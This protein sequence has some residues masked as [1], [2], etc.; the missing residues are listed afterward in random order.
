M[1][2]VLKS[3]RV[4]FA[5]NPFV[6]I[7]DQAKKTGSLCHIV[8]RVGFNTEEVMVCLVSNT[9]YKDIKQLSSPPTTPSP[10][11]TTSKIDMDQ[12]NSIVKAISAT[13][14]VKCVLY[15]FNP[16]PM[17][18][19][20]LGEERNEKS[21]LLF[22]DCDFIHE[23]VAGIRVRVSLQSFMQSNPLQAEVLY[24]KVVELANFVGSEV[25][26]DMFCGVGTISLFVAPFVRQ[27]IGVEDCK[28]AVEDAEVNKELN[29]IQNVRFICAKAEDILSTSE[30]VNRTVLSGLLDGEYYAPEDV[31]AILNPPRKGCEE[32]LLVAL[33]ERKVRKVVY[34]SCNP[35]SLARDLDVLV[36]KMGYTLDKVSPVDMFPHTTHVEV[37]CLLTLQVAQ[38]EI[39]RE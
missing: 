26:W 9:K 38:H 29:N 2:D 1:N 28:P 27:V 11:S 34:V 18:G 4:Y 23:V 19:N 7:F 24:R 20:I 6:S 37:V 21:K 30:N 16:H 36:G 10:S 32:S 35:K 17:D 33:A 22:G 31:V 5:K 8:I 25:V 15:N 3:L 14:G 39:D 12:L 13:P